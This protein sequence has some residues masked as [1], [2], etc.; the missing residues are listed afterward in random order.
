MSVLELLPLALLGAVVGMDVVTFPQAMISRPIV[1]ATLAG[2]MVGNPLL[3]LLAVATLELIALETLPVGAS[4]Y[5]EWGSASVVGGALFADRGAD[6]AHAASALVLAVL[7]G[8][9]TAWIGGWTMY[10]LRRLNAWMAHRASD[11]VHAGDRHAVVGLQLRGLT[12]DLLRAGALTLLALVASGALMDAGLARWDMNETISRAVVAGIAG[13]SA[14]A[15]TWTLTHTT[16][17]ARWFLVAGL[18][19]GVLLV[20]VR[21]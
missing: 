5:P 13:A 14:L 8:V 6:P 19:V 16:V 1:A 2:A 21:L 20:L 4:R 3:G 17:A 11:R 10:E 7:A 18:A 9:A 15:A 12:A